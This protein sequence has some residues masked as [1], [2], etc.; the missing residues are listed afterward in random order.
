MDVMELVPNGLSKLS[1]FF[2]FLFQLSDLSAACLNLR[3]E[4][5][6]SGFELRVRAGK[7]IEYLDEVLVTS[8][9]LLINCE[10][11]ALCCKH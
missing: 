7:G 3:Y 4:L 5:L 1:L 2:E 9:E 8:H 10:E 6:L 11:V